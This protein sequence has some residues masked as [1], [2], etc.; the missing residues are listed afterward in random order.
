[1]PYVTTQ[2]PNMGLLAPASDRQPP[3]ASRDNLKHIKAQDMNTRL[4]LRLS[5]K[6]N[7]ICSYQ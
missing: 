4:G 5:Y 6:Q 2:T 1:M 3:K 7:G